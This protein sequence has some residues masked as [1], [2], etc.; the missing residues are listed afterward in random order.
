ME[1][2]D[3]SNASD[4]NQTLSFIIDL[5]FAVLIV[6]VINFFVVSIFNLS[7]STLMREGIQ[8]SMLERKLEIYDY[9]SLGYVSVIII[10]MIFGR[11][12]FSLASKL[13]SKN[14]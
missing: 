13:L 5:V 12:Y 9:I 4:K 7:E 2:K 14:K 8:T 1:K 11:S 10:Y 6:S 3:S